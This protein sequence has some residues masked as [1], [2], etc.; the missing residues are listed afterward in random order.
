M[1]PPC[2]AAPPHASPTREFLNITGIWSRRPSTLARFSSAF[3]TS[4]SGSGQ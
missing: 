2:T 3:T 1:T 4:I